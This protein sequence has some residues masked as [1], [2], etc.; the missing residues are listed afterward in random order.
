MQTLTSLV[1]AVMSAVVAL[2]A[3]DLL[4]ADGASAGIALGDDR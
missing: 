2:V 4:G 3:P 1:V